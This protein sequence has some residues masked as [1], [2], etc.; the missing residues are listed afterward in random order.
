MS[1]P[2]VSPGQ[3]RGLDRRVATL[4]LGTF[5][6]GTE[7]LVIAGILP[8]LAAALGV[9]L[10]Q[11]GLLVTLF[12][13]AYAGA[14]PVLGVALAHV[15]RRRLL[16]AAMGVFALSNLAAALAPGYAVV[17][18][19]RVVAGLSASAYTPAAVGAAVHLLPPERRGRAAGTVFAGLSIALVTAVPLGTYLAH[20]ADWRATFLF[21]AAVSTLATLGVAVLLPRIE[22]SGRVPLRARLAPLRRTEVA[23]ALATAFVWMT[24]AFVFYTFVVRLVGVAT[25]WPAASMGAVLF[26]YGLCAVLGNALGARSTDGPLGESGTLVTALSSLFIG[27]LVLAAAVHW[28]PPLGVAL[29]PAAL[30]VLALA[31]WACTA[32]QSHRMISLAP[33]AMSEVLGLNTMANYLGVSAGAALGA[34]LV[35]RFSPVSLPLVAGACQLLGLLGVLQVDRLRAARPVR[36]TG[37]LEEPVMPAEAPAVAPVVAPPHP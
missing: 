24:G 8:E 21:V 9:G 19:A 3:P 36:P 14:A 28:G 12:A 11:A 34:L 23:L 16:I 17:A 18:L 35:E 26:G 15:E 2:A 25:G 27:Y 13:V 32:P 1:V 37:G 33:G 20:L 4:A 5:A 31:G 10:G 7:S 30:V 6:I 29:A 22:S